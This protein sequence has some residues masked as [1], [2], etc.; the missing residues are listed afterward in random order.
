[1]LKDCRVDYE[2]PVES[3]AEVYVKNGD[4]VPTRRNLRIV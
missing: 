2:K 3:P 1:M 4:G